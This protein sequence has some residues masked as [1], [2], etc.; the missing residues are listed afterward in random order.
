MLTDTQAAGLAGPHAPAET[1]PVA[2]EQPADAAAAAASHEAASAL[3][4]TSAEPVRAEVPAGSSSAAPQARGQKRKA[5][6]SPAEESDPEV[7]LALWADVMIELKLLGTLH[8]HPAS[9][10]RTGI[11]G[12]M[13]W[14]V[15]RVP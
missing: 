10:C 6:D 1:Q 3:A 5:I 15:S 12:Q 14:C 2:V 9:A 13:Y 11:Q 8:A 4:A 7:K